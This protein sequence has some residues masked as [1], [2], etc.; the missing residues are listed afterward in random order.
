[1][2]RP[3]VST[4]EELRGLLQRDPALSEL[5][6]RL[7]E[8][9]GDDPAHDGSHAERVALWTLR[10]APQLPARQCIAAALL[11]DV[12]SLP[13]N[14]PERAKSSELSARLAWDL[15]PCVGFV[16][17][18]IRAICDAIETHS[19]SR[20]LPPRSELGRALQDADRLE[21]LGA[22]G[23]CRTLSTGA[24][25][26]ARYFDDSDPWAARRALDDRSYTV[27]H[28]FTKLLGLAETMQTPG[29]RREAEKRIDFMKCFL[30]QLGVEIGCPPPSR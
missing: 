11:H 16:L 25:M 15:L 6:A 8:R 28:F 20:A 30:V 24:R 21:A 22:L 10:L 18:E 17:E 12:V 26:G 19:H 2:N 13:K 29:G 3:V 4:L 1:M 5:R 14:S 23:L 7:D 27:D 9:A